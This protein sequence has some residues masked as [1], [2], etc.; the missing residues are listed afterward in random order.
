MTWP[1][2]NF[3]LFIKLSYRLNFVPKY[4]LHSSRSVT[5]PRCSLVQSQAPPAMWTVAP[6]IWTERRPWIE[7][8]F[9]WSRQ[10]TATCPR[11]IGTHSRK[12]LEL[13]LGTSWW[14]SCHRHKP[15]QDEW[16]QKFQTQ[17]LTRHS[18]G[19]WSGPTSYSKPSQWLWTHWQRCRV[20]GAKRDASRCARNAHSILLSYP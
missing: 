14:P 18:T 1:K 20:W 9:V 11:S 13:V 19:A 4:R 6:N 7:T 15:R 2:I 10:S 17:I 3:V 12:W 8:S 5:T 16:K